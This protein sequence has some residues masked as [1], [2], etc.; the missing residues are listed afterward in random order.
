M[1]EQEKTDFEKMKKDFVCFWKS[2]KAGGELALTNLEV[3]DAVGNTIPELQ[4]V[5]ELYMKEI[6]WFLKNHATNHN[7]QRIFGFKF[8]SNRAWNDFDPEPK[9][10]AEGKWTVACIGCR[11][12]EAHRNESE[13]FETLEELL[14]EHC[15]GDGNAGFLCHQ[16]QFDDQQ[17]INAY[18]Q[19]MH[20][21]YEISAERARRQEDDRD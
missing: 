18:R 21:R 15:D 11:C 5:N 1:S 13:E 4:R 19:M 14:E 6:W 10:N 8:E 16:C 3:N 9:Q 12:S 17:T 2:I 7:L 20:E